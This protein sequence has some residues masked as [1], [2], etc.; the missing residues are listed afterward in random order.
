MVNQS[1]DV[2]NKKSDISDNQLCEQSYREECSNSMVPTQIVTSKSEESHIPLQLSKSSEEKSNH[3]LNR[4]KTESFNLEDDSVY[5]K[6]SKQP[7]YQRIMLKFEE[8]L[9]SKCLDVLL[10]QQSEKSKNELVDDNLHNDSDA[11]GGKTQADMD[12]AEL[13]FKSLLSG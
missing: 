3:R 2:L 10:C 6:I 8:H 13:N 1:F 9:M 12:D 11:S 5:T 4:S 7:I